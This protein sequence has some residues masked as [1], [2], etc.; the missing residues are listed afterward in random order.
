MRQRIYLVHAYRYSVA[1]CEEAFARLW[2]QAQ[3]IRLLDEGL[4]ADAGAD[5]SLPVNI[6]ERLNGLFRHCVA[7]GA[8]GIVF[9]GSTFGPAVDAAREGIDVPLLKADEAMAELAVSKAKR[10]VLLATAKRAIPVIRGNLE[11]AAARAGVTPGIDEVWV[12]GAQAANNGGR[13]VEHDALVAAA[14]ERCSE[15]ADAIVLG[16]MSMAPARALMSE[17]TA[18]RVLTSPDASALRMR[19]ILGG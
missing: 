12:A 1:P 19:S 18:R 13:S 5:G 17:P 10:I 8:N 14:A 9:T 6:V 7:S 4:Y 3:A 2:P 11:A 16:Q 15:G